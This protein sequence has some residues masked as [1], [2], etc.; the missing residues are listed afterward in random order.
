MTDDFYLASVPDSVRLLG[1]DLRPLS[2]GHLILL[3]RYGSAFLSETNEPPT[4]SDLAISVLVCSLSYVEGLALR[5][6]ATI[7]EFMR[8]W[9]DR[10][11]GCDR[12]LVK[13][14]FKQPKL[15]DLQKEC[16]AFSAY[17]SEHSKIPYYYFN[18]SDFQ[19]MEC[20]SVQL[21][22]V[23]LMR[24]MKFTEAELMDR[25][26]ALCL[27]DYVTLKAMEGEIKLGNRDDV[28]SAQDAA[29]GLA[30]AIAAGK[31][32]VNGKAKS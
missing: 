8:R 15:L 2:L 22:K 11:T 10:I 13:L 7:D 6:D 16:D 4:F 32:D 3:R 20:P 26:W 9:H 30:E 12:L 24:D 29:K 27:W 28:A 23:R 19:A 25:S 21:V 31:I 14:G 1:L 18:P 5:H 17:L